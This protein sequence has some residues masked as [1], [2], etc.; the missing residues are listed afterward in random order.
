MHSQVFLTKTVDGHMLSKSNTKL[1]SRQAR[2]KL[3]DE[4]ARSPKMNCG[5][6]FGAVRREVADK[7]GTV[8]MQLAEYVDPATGVDYSGYWLTE[9]SPGGG[10][11]M[12]VLPASQVLSRGA[13]HHVSAASL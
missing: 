7:Y 13:L 1:D 9:Y 10:V 11:Q 4:K 3:I 12:H 6:S 8:R 5:T 2:Q